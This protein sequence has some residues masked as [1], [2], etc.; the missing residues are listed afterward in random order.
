MEDKAN[1]E[2]LAEERLHFQMTDLRR[3][4]V[5]LQQ[6]RQNQTIRLKILQ[7]DLKMQA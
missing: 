3:T 2:V 7:R 5:S 4:F 6:I 1:A